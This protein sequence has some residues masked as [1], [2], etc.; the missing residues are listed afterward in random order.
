MSHLRMAHLQILMLDNVIYPAWTNIFT[1]SDYLT[2][3][4]NIVFISITKA[5]LFLSEFSTALLP[6]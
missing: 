5:S 3:A 6:Y 2:V 4:D 1:A